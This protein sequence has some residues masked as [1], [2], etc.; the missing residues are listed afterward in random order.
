[1]P[2]IQIHLLEG[3][4]TEVK[5]QLMREM[6]EIV[7]RTLDVEPSQVRIL[8]NELQKENWSVSGIAKDEQTN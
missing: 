7:C 6:N 3:R 1:M 4:N 8:I 2:I 5:K